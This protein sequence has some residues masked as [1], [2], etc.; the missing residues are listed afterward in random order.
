MIDYNLEM[1]LLQQTSELF[2]LACNYLVSL[3]A[4]LISMY[5]ILYMVS[6]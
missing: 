2:F 1:A 6:G 3:M 5:V 4:E